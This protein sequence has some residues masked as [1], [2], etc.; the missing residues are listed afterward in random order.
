LS[1]QISS[2]FIL[3]RNYIDIVAGNDITQ[4]MIEC[5]IRTAREKIDSAELP[6]QE[7][8]G[9]VGIRF[10]AEIGLHEIV[11]QEY[12]DLTHAAVILF[13]KWKSKKQNG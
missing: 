2:N 10:G 4:D 11:F 12:N 7:I 3:N 6:F 8:I 1:S 9:S 13:N 5:A